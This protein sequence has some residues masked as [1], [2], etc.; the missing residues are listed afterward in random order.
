MFKF[1]MFALEQFKGGLHG[2]LVLLSHRSN[3]H[4]KEGYCGLVAEIEHEM[5]KHKTVPVIVVLL[6][7]ATL[8]SAPRRRMLSALHDFSVDPRRT[9]ALKRANSLVQ[10]A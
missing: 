8:P 9:T 5:T 2:G 3:P 1:G 6:A 4:L 7:P 10:H